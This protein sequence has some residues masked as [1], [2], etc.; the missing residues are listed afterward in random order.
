MQQATS[1]EIGQELHFIAKRYR[2]EDWK[3]IG[4]YMG[5]NISVR[6]EYRF[7]GSFDRNIFCVEG[8]SG[9]K[10]EC[11]LSGALPLSFVESADYPRATLEK[12]FTLISRQQQKIDRLTNEL[13]TLQQIVARQWNKSDELSALKQECSELQ[14]K[15]DESLKQTDQQPTPAVDDAA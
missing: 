6:S 10:Y 5:L 14:N 1:K 15:I 11:G 13:P 2:G 3:T 7:S 4:H 12:L 9:L 8:L